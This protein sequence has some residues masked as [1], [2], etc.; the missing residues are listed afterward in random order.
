MVRSVHNGQRVTHLQSQSLEGDILGASE[1]GLVLGWSVNGDSDGLS[2]G[3]K[4]TSDESKFPR[5]M[6]LDSG[7]IKGL[8]HLSGQRRGQQLARLVRWMAIDS[9]EMHLAKTKL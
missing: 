3:I 6:A 1:V 9:K 4:A 2:P 5:K 8:S 7:Q